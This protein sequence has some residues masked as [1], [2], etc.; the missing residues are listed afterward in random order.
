MSF[1]SYFDLSGQV[2]ER[3]RLKVAKETSSSVDES[4]DPVAA[5]KDKADFLLTFNGVHAKAEVCACHDV[6]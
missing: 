3:Q 2:E 5:A 6:T 1:V 4:Y